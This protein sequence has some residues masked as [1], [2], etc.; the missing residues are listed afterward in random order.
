MINSTKTTPQ[1]QLQEKKLKSDNEKKND[2][3]I[4]ENNINMD[5]YKAKK[6]NYNEGELCSG[7][8]KNRA[9]I[10]VHHFLK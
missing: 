3:K 1:K 10:N 8:Q 2:A 4:N 9:Q 6:F 5:A 7:K